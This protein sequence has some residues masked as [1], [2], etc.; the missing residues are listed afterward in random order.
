MINIFF[1]TF[2]FMNKKLNPVSGDAEFGC[3][4]SVSVFAHLA[5]SVTAYTIVIPGFENCYP[6]VV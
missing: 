3:C 5:F 6:P 2:V 1:I 4:F